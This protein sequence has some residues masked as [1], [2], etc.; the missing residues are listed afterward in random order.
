MLRTGIFENSV[1]WLVRKGEKKL[2]KKKYRKKK[3]N[4]RFSIGSLSLSILSSYIVFIVVIY[5]SLF[6]V[7]QKT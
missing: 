1:D 5:E 6:S 3:M 2:F 7:C 4:T